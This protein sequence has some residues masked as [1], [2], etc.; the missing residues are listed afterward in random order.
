MVSD[1]TSLSAIDDPKLR[2]PSK[3]AK[4]VVTAI[5]YCGIEVRGSTYVE[6]MISKGYFWI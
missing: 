1:T 2:R 3:H 6:D 5:E 4:V